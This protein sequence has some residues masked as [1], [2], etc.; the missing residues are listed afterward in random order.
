MNHRS[1]LDRDLLM[2]GRAMGGSGVR[3]NNRIRVRTQDKK[4]N[5]P[6]S[7]HDVKVP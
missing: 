2:E 3:E 5:Y 6:P 4:I 1:D 7:K